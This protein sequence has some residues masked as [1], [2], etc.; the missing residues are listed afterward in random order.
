MGCEPQPHDPSLSHGPTSSYLDSARS[1]GAHLWGV[2]DLPQH[3]CS[4]EML[5]WVSLFTPSP[6]ER[7]QEADVVP[8]LKMGILRSQRALGLDGQSV[9]N[10]PWWIYGVSSILE[11]TSESGPV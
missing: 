8:T 1:L 7:K 2:F 3:L 9:V 11:Q 6:K 5:Q 10:S 4:K